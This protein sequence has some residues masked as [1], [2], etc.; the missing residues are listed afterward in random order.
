MREE[1]DYVAVTMM[2]AKIAGRLGLWSV[3]SN[4]HPG[5]AEDVETAE[6]DSLIS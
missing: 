3:T 5:E 6:K 2:I 1:L 4:R